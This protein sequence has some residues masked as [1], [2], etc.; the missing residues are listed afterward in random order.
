MLNYT[1]ISGADTAMISTTG[2]SLY[3]SGF[4]QCNLSPHVNNTKRLIKTVRSR[5]T[6]MEIFKKKKKH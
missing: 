4:S 2:Q 5:D 3:Q 1:N 6:N